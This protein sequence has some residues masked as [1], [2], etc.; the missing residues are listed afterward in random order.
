MKISSSDVSIGPVPERATALPSPGNR[1][2]LALDHDDYDH[3]KENFSK[4]FIVITMI[5][6][7]TCFSCRTTTHR[8][9]SIGNGT[10]V[11]CF[12]MVVGLVILIFFTSSKK[13]G[14]H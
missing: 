14:E 3:M 6:S 4:L 1:F 13:D 11:T 2:S 12:L 9:D 5:I 7:F 8:A 10:L